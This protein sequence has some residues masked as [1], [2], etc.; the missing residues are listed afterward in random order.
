MVDEWGAP[1]CYRNLESR[2]PFRGPSRRLTRRAG[3]KTG[4]CV[5]LCYLPGMAFMVAY[6]ACLRLRVI[7]VPVYPPD[8]SKLEIGLKKL[9]LVQQS[10]EAR[11]CL[12]ETTLDQMRQAL[13][14]THTWPTGLAWRR[15]DDV[16]PLRPSARV[17]D[18]SPD[19]SA[20]A[21]LQYTSGSTG[22]PKGVMLTFENIWHNINHVYLP[23]QMNNLRRRGVDVE[24]E[25]IVGVSWLPQ[26]HDTGLVLC[27]TAPF[28]AGYRMVNFSPLTFLRSPLLWVQAMSKYGAHWSAAPD[29]AY[30]LCVRRLEEQVK[31]KNDVV[32]DLSK[33]VQ[34][35]CGAGE[36]CRPR[37]LAGFL[38]T[39]AKL[40]LRD[41][42]FVP[43]YGLA[44]HVVG[45]CGCAAIILSKARPDLACCGE[46]FQVDVR[47]VDPYTFKDAARGEIWLSSKS[48]AK[49]YWGKPELSAETFSAQRVLPDGSLAPYLYLRTGDEGFL[50]DGRLYICG[51]LKDLIIVGGKNY[52]PEDIEIVAQDAAPEI[53][54]GCV[55][56]FAAKENSEDAEETVVC[57]FELRAKA[58]AALSAE[59]LAALCERVRRTVGVKTGLLPERIV[60]IPERSIPKTTS[61]KVQ[62]RNTRA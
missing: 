11:L 60:A 52:F 34:L 61:G 62:R 12:T 35:A 36:R 49:G 42:V 26:F 27:I 15:T 7:A 1:C 38:D 14:L 55:A 13:S 46:D 28:V 17:I 3:V 58:T 53:R 47:I 57:V 25:V 32:I 51:R 29:F 19:D 39:F 50:E 8:P 5:L 21:F 30:E 10:C 31:G 41:D 43:N 9:G 20:V 22:D 16:K 45:T 33:V 54:P 2:S 40:G 4:D 59:D 56:A 6:W 23:A 37:Q 44:E 24:T 48:C 18:A